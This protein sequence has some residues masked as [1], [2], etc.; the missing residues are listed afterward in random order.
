MSNTRFPLMGTSVPPLLGRDAILKRIM[1]A[2]T[3]KVPD[4]LQVVGPKFVGKTLILHEIVTRLQLTGS[5]YS[6]TVIW[7][8]GHQTPANNNLFM[9]RFSDVLSSALKESHPDYAEHLKHPQG[10]PFYD[11]LEVLDLLKDEGGKVLVIMDGFDK[12]LSNGKL[13][14]NLWDQLRELALMPSLRLVTASRRTLR[15]LI[16]HPD[17]QTSD[18][19]NIFDPT[20]VRVGCFDESDLSMILAA[21]PDIELTDGA[22]TELWNASNGFPVIM[23]GILNAVCAEG[24]LGVISPE[25]MKAACDHAFSSLQATVDTLWD[26]CH[27]SS[28]D[29]LRRV[30]E[31]NNVPRSGIAALDA[32]TLIERGFVHSAANKLIRP[33]QILVR[34]LNEQPNE[35]N[36]LVRLFAADD[37]FQKNLKGVLELRIEQLIDIDSTLKRYLKRG[38]EDMPDHPGVFLSNVRGIVNQAFELIWKAELGN[39]IIPSG[40]MSIWKHN[41]ERVDEWQTAFPQGRQRVRLLN[42]MTGSERCDPTARYVTKGTYVLMNAVYAIGDF[43]QHQEGAHID[44]GTAY[45]ALHLCIELAAALARELPSGQ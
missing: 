3:K 6:A 2:L 31:Q 29:L 15:D 22:K 40:W 33:S 37:A 43:G 32:E 27:P 12:P 39:K 44:S 5:P 4:H 7:D 28:K 45:V 24:T 19:W 21:V 30:L 36:A 42:L 35:C 14:R 34:Y 13:T 17:A 1:G 10:N 41:G 20:P 23:L 16:R 26:D 25:K 18:F 9:Q 11:I 38:T 8:L